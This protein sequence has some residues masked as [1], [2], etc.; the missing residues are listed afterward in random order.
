MIRRKSSTHLSALVALLV[1][2]ARAE[3]PEMQTI[4][5]ASPS[6]SNWQIEV[7]EFFSYACPHATILILICASGSLSLKRR[8]AQ[9]RTCGRSVVLH[10]LRLGRV[11]TSLRQ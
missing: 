8:G 11:Y 5:P 1:C 10:G 2:S 6:G 3:Q 7:L 9:A 4:S